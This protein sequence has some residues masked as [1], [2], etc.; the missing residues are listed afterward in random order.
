MR[1]YQSELMMEG[2]FRASV[3]SINPDWRELT[4]AFR[5]QIGDHPDKD[6]LLVVM[7]TAYIS[8]LKDKKA[9]SSG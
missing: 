4:D 7:A 2:L 1:L 8:Y 9:S 6:V 5:K 3:K